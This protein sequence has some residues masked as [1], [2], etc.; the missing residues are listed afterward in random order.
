VSNDQKRKA[1][2]GLTVRILGLDFETTGLLASE[3]R[4]IE[5]GAVVW[6]TDSNKPVHVFSE[7]V[8]PE[9]FVGLPDT[10]IKVTGIEDQDLYDFGISTQVAF[11]RLNELIENSEYVVAHN[12]KFDQSFYEAEISRLGLE[13][14]DRPWLD[15]VTDV[16]YGDEVGSRKLTYLAADHGIVNAYAHR[17]V[18]DSLTMMT[19]LSRYDI[20]EVVDRAK[21]PSVSVLAHVSFEEKD[22]AKNLGFKWDGKNK[23]WY[24][25]YKQCDLET[26][27][28][29]FEYSVQD[30]NL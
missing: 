15:T 18:F 10:I 14:V 5:I 28:F 12:V 11:E 30:A 7:L 20:Q 1:N 9:G 17:A 26:V 4:V 24:R 22:K 2:G 29:P 3:D 19:I 16:P 21:S 25:H 13:P 23:K 6:D 8:K 27:N